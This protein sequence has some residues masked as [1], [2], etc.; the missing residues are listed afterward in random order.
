MMNLSRFFTLLILG[1]FVAGSSF[2]ATVTVPG[3]AVT[4]NGALELLDYNDGEADTVII[5]PGTYDEQVFPKGN[6]GADSTAFP[7]AGGLTTGAVQASVASHPD[8]LTLRGSDPNNPPVIRIDTYLPSPYGMFP[9]DP[10]DFFFS[11]FVYGAH[12]VTCVNIE[13][14]SNPNDYAKNG[15][16]TNHVW[17]D[18]LFTNGSGDG[19]AG[20]DFCDYNNNFEF[21][22]D[23]DPLIGLDNEYVYSNCIIDG[24]DL[25]DGN[26]ARFGNAFVWWHGY[27]TGAPA[28][29]AQGSGVTFD[30]CVIRHWDDIVHRVNSNQG[31]AGGTTPGSGLGPFTMQDCF[32]SDTGAVLGIAGAQEDVTVNRNVYDVMSDHFVRLQDRDGRFPSETYIFSN[33]ITMDNGDGVAAFRVSNTVEAT[34]R[35][36]IV[37]N[38]LLENSNSS[39]AIR[40]EGGPSP[41]GAIVTIANNIIDGSATG[42]SSTGIRTTDTGLTVNL[43]NNAIFDEVTAVDGTPSSEVGTVTSA[44][45]YDSTTLVIPT[46]PPTTRPVQGYVPSGVDYV[47]GGD[48]ASYTAIS[49]VV[50]TADVDSTNARDTNPDIGAQETNGPSLVGGW[51]MY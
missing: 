29:T 7:S 48:N 34:A 2:A 45:G 25:L 6:A 18:C 37:N 15:M 32:L 42:L 17:Q 16:A 41:A 51:D 40:L 4:I 27:G 1:A 43:I 20:E 30:N 11:S 26:G 44:P 47:D 38:T 9:G 19:G 3:N 49:G 24:E 5:S 13:L 12:D 23:Q 31:G 46:S 8:A 28:R 33:N 50:G 36:H 14:R 10:G 35:I 21:N 39:G 22:S